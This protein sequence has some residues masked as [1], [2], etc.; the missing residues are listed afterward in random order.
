MV[1]S[2]VTKPRRSKRERWFSTSA[3]RL[4]PLRD[5]YRTSRCATLRPSAARGRAPSG[6]R[7]FDSVVGAILVRTI[8]AGGVRRPVPWRPGDAKR[9]MPP[10]TAGQSA[11]PVGG[12]RA[13]GA[14][15]TGQ[16][17]KNSRNHIG[18][19][20][21]GFREFASTHTSHSPVRKDRRAR[22]SIRDD[23]LH[24]CDRLRQAGRQSTGRRSGNRLRKRSLPAWECR[25]SPGRGSPYRTS[26]PFRVALR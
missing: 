11:P 2:P 6:A 20:R 25:T 10:G 4:A 19:A 14:Q 7:R 8:I 23:T 24:P 17:T 22:L 16:G 26:P 21:E 5:A 12:P 3:A 15:C 1:A 18:W 9:A 13:R